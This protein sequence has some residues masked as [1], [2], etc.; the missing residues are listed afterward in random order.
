[1]FRK[2]NGREKDVDIALTKE[3]LVNAF[4]QNCEEVILIAGDEDYVELIE[5][6]KRYGQ[7]IRGAFF[8]IGLSEHLR[9]SLDQFTYID[10]IVC[11]PVFSGKYESLKFAIERELNSKIPKLS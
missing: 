2:R 4:Q 8:K 6:V 10:S 11:N 3:M 1:M 9:I 5:E 7:N